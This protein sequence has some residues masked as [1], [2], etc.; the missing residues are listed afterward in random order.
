MGRWGPGNM[1]EDCA[2]DVL[3][4]FCAGL[5]KQTISL[6]G[7]QLAAEYDEVQH[8]QLF[9][10]F[11]ILFLLHEKDMLSGLPEPEELE[12]VRDLFLKRYDK[13]SEQDPYPERRQVIVETFA[14]F[15]A[16]CREEADGPQLQIIEPPAVEE[17]APGIDMREVL[18]FDG[19]VVLEMPAHWQ[20]DTYDKRLAPAPNHLLALVSAD[21][22]DIIRLRK[23]AFECKPRPGSPGHRCAR[24]CSDRSTFPT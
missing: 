21:D 10:N 24:I 8:A 15:H 7:S 19:S 23:D 12:T 11:E 16:M 20:L 14:R 4:E 5:V 6:A 3:C 17:I 13:Y 22:P 2:L 1:D 9:V 18:L